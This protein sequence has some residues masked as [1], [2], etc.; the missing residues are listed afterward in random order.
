MKPYSRLSGLKPALFL[1]FCLP[2]LMQAVAQKDYSIN[3]EESLLSKKESMSIEKAIDHQIAFFNRLF[4]DNTSQRSD[5][6][7]TVFKTYD[8]FL[9]YQVQKGKQEIRRSN[10]YYSVRDKEV[11]IFKKEKNQSFL[12]I[13]YHELCHFFT[14]KYLQLPPPWLNEGLATYFESIKIGSKNITHA[15]D[16]IL[17]A[18][19]KTLIQL[20]EIKLKDF[21]AWNYKQFYDKSFSDEN[22][23]YAI[24][25]CMVYYL[26]NNHKEATYNLIREI[27]KDTPSE[28][29]FDLFYPGGFLQF[30]KDFLDYYSK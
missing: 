5:V 24:S 19:V 21:I 11:V 12:R 22:Y 1:F 28:E 14:H 25:H 26:L 7:V 4:P 15:E 18:R 16:A 6:T 3:D 17:K 13:C 30:E 10:G 23:G 29:A 8:K 2:L 20:R 27:A 9:K